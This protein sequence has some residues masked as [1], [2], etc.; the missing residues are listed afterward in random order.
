M[1]ACV[2]ACV[3]AYAMHVPMY[4][5]HHNDSSGR[6]L[7]KRQDGDAMYAMHHNDSSGRPL[8]KRRDGDAM[9]AMHHNDS[10]G[11][12]LA[13]RG[14]VMLCMPCTITTVQGDH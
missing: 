6:P 7:A 1:R 14:M 2:R 4:A 5:M 8:A 10:S 9:Y 3:R 12:P 11:R 13:K